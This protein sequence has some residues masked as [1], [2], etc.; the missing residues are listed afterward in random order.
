MLVEIARREARKAVAKIKSALRT[1]A[2]RVKVTRKTRAAL[3]K[4]FEKAAADADRYRTAGRTPHCV[5]GQ[6]SYPGHR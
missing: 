6:R 1:A 2:T 3:E 4:R 5:D